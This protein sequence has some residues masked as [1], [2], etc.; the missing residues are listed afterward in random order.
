MNNIEQSLADELQREDDVAFITTDEELFKRA[1]TTA[2]VQQGTND[3]I[4]LGMASIWVA[5]AG[6]FINILKPTFKNM[7]DNSRKNNEH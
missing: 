3:L 4:S 6:I 5:F 7:A 2:N 1:E